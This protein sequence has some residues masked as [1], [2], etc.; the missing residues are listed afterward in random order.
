[1]QEI[2]DSLDGAGPQLAFASTTLI[3]GRQRLAFGLID[4]SNKVLYAP[5]ALYLADAPD[6]PARG[7]F[8]APAD[9]LITDPPYQSRQAASESDP[10]AAVYETEVDLP[11][12]GRQVVLAVSRV[13]GGFYGATGSLRVRSKRSD[14]VA[15][16]GDPAPRVDTDTTTS[17]AGD[18]DAIDTRRPKDSMHADNLADA[19]GTKPIALLFATPQL[20]QSRVCGPVVDIAEQLKATYGDRMTFIHQEVYV[21]NDPSKG[22]RPALKAFGLQ[23]EPWLFVIDARGRIAARVEGSFGFAAFE[24][25]IRAGLQGG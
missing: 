3:P 2:A 17:A 5:S 18:L 23:T 4:A 7:P 1:M 9:L 14:S 12:T 20:C 19:A 25:A 16:V 24:R 11:R 10:F 8:Q 6:K 21:D 13:N 15:G 22:L